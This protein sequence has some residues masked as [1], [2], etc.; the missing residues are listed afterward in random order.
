VCLSTVISG[1]AK[2]AYAATESLAASTMKNSFHTDTELTQPDRPLIRIKRKGRP[3][4]TCS[5]C[6]STPCSS[7]MEHARIKRDAEIKTPNSKVTQIHKSK[8]FSLPERLVANQ[9]RDSV[10]TAGKAT[11]GR[12]FQR[13]KP[14][15]YLPIAP[16]PLE[17]DDS[18]RLSSTSASASG[19]TSSSHTPAQ[20]GLSSRRESA[21][22]IEWSGSEG[23]GTGLSRVLS[24]AEGLNV[25]ISITCAESDH[26][27]A[28]SAPDLTLDPFVSG[29]I[30]DPTYSMMPS[31]SVSEARVSQT[32]PLISPLEVNQF[33]FPL[34]PALTLDGDLGYLEDI[35]VNITGS[36]SE[37]IFQVEDWSRYMWSPETGFEH[38]DTV[39]SSAQ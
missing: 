11:H 20:E 39:Y 16:R 18:R 5:I 26:S 2:P 31:L 19:P 34:D 1:L 14:A 32:G 22:E 36:L 15:D 4:A 38:L 23:S 7:P 17:R 3:F 13:H 27:P 29:T 30:F 33:D 35:D 6:C 24:Y 9:G 37:E 10:R 21:N 8:P 28:C 12:L 25:S